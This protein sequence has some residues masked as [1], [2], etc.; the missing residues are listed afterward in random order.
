MGQLGARHFGFGGGRVRA[1]SSTTRQRKGA[2]PLQAVYVEAHTRNLLLEH[3]REV[4]A[5]RGMLDHLRAAAAN[6]PETH[7]LLSRLLRQYESPEG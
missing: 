4:T 3:P 7:R 6:N 2:P 1:V 5:H